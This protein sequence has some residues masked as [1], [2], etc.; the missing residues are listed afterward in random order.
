MAEPDQCLYTFSD[1]NTNKQAVKQE[2]HWLSG[3]VCMVPCCTAVQS[4][5]PPPPPPGAGG[6]ALGGATAGLPDTHRC[7]EGGCEVCPQGGRQ[8]CTAADEQGGCCIH[9]AMGEIGVA[10]CQGRAHNSH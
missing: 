8:D 6:G 10:G 9:H 1:C 5:T 3:L 2:F 7:I 4:W